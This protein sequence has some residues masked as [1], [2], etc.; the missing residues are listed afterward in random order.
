MSLVKYLFGFV[1]FGIISTAIGGN[2]VPSLDR[3]D[4]EDIKRRNGINMY[5]HDLMPRSY[6][7]STLYGNCEISENHL[8]LNKQRIVELVQQCESGESKWLKL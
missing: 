5:S 2:T 1:L 6:K 7:P 3:E 4:M 8:M